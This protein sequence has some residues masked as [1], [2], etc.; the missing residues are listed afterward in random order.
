MKTT[1]DSRKENFLKQFRSLNAYLKK[2]IQKKLPHAVFVTPL[3]PQLS[4][5]VA[6]INFPEKKSI[7]VFQKLYESHG[8]ACASTVGIRLSPH[9]YNSMSDIHKVEQ[10]LSTLVA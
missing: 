7:E 8:I 2:Q 5:G 6:V 9:V 1:P 10:A 3:S 4:A